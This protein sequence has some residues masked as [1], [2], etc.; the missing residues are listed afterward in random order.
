VTGA[1]K[2]VVR[3]LLR[4]ANDDV[5]ELRGFDLGAANGLGRGNGCEFLRR[6]ILELSAIARHGSTRASNDGDISF[7][8][9]GEPEVLLPT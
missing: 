6:E 3:C 5:I 4:V 7:I 9:H 1:V 2:R 8:G